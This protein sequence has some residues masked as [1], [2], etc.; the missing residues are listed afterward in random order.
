MDR[1][2]VLSQGLASFRVVEIETEPGGE[3]PRA[4]KTA[5]TFSQRLL[6]DFSNVHRP[7]VVPRWRDVWRKQGSRPQ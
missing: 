5:P 4:A 3:I 6:K 7:R 1:K 2:Q